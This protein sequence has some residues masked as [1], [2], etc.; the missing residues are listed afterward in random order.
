MA[1]RCYHPSWPT[2]STKTAGDAQCLA[3]L[4]GF[5]VSKLNTNTETETQMLHT[6]VVQ[7]GSG[8]GEIV[9]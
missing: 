9:A 3:K 5:G 6:S 4:I 8:V 1:Y 2:K 7:G